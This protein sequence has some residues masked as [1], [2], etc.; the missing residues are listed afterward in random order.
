MFNS[1]NACHSYKPVRLLKLVKTSNFCS[2]RQSRFHA[3]YSR[4]KSL[5]ASRLEPS[6]LTTFRFTLS[7]IPIA[8]NAVSCTF[9]IVLSSSHNRSLKLPRLFTNAR[10]ALQM[11]FVGKMRNEMS[12]NS[13]RMFSLLSKKLISL[14]F[15]GTLKQRTHLCCTKPTMVHG[16]F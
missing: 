2:R 15:D 4:H 5:L 1:K 8:F 16:T 13:L 7:G 6:F 11:L 12:S 9:V 3:K 14:L 10:Q